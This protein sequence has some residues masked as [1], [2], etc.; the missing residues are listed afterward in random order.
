LLSSVCIQSEH[1]GTRSSSIMKL[2]SQFEMEFDE[3]IL[4]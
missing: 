3:R 4:R 1:Y 2:N